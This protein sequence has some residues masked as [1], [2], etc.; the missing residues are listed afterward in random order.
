MGNPAL[1]DLFGCRDDDDRGRACA[2]DFIG[3]C[4]TGQSDEGYTEEEAVHNYRTVAGWLTPLEYEDAAN[5]AFDRLSYEQRGQ[6]KG[7]LRQRTAGRLDVQNDDPR[8]LARATA[9]FREQEAG[10]GGLASLFGEGGGAGR[11]HPLAKA[12]LGGVAAVALKKVL[13]CQMARAPEPRP[14]WIRRPEITR[15]IG[16]LEPWSPVPGAARDRVGQEASAT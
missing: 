15:R 10:G 13:S 2:L 7:V 9:R 11:G 5:E 16:A 12:A 6:L 3:R 14:A 4:E 8:D 1:D